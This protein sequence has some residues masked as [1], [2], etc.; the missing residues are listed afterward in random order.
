M[1]LDELRSEIADLLAD[2]AVLLA[3][4]IAPELA[5]RLGQAANAASTRLL[6]DLLGD[7]EHAASAAGVLLATLAWGDGDPPDR[8]WH[9]PIGRAIART[10]RADPDQSVRASTAA[11]MLGVSPQRVGVL[12]E[13]GKLGRT[14]EGRVSHQSVLDRLAAATG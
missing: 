8:W 4:A 7:D 11:R 1:T 10:T 5:A 9:T 14:P 6:G 2:R 3:E 13:E 12:L